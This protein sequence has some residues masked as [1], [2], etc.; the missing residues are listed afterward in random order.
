MKTLKEII[1]TI[2]I[3]LHNKKFLYFLFF[4]FLGRVIIYI[5]IACFTQP[6]YG[7]FTKLEHVILTIIVLIWAMLPYIRFMDNIFPSRRRV[8]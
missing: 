2:R 5:L 4:E 1:K 3:H 7:E 8:Y 6:S